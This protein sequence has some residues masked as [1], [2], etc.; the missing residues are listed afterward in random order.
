MLDVIIDIGINLLIA[1]IVVIPFGVVFYH[2]ISKILHA[3]YD[4]PEDD[5]STNSLRVDIRRYSLM[6]DMLLTLFCGSVIIRIWIIK[7]EYVILSLI[8]TSFL[9]GLFLLSLLYLMYF[10]FSF[11]KKYF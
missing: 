1:I 11:R 8:P 5:E 7:G 6:M 4:N 2:W 10:F 3:N 9:G